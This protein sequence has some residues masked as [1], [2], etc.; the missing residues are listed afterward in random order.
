MPQRQCI[1]PK[2]VKLTKCLKNVLY[3]SLKVLMKKKFFS[4]SAMVDLLKG[5]SFFLKRVSHAY[6]LLLT[7]LSNGGQFSKNFH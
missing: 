5:F 6:S 1:L 3:G 2:T 4:K 7:W